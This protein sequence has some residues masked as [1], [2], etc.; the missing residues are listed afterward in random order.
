MRKHEG[1]VR[2]LAAGGHRQGISLAFSAA[3]LGEL[4]CAVGYADERAAGNGSV[5]IAGDGAALRSSVARAVRW[6]GRIHRTASSWHKFG[7]TRREEEP[8]GGYK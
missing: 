8:G 6:R 2:S 5:G 4:A 1:L 3:H 7:T